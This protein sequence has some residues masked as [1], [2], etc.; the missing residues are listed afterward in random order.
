[1]IRADA[2]REFT[3]R[4]EYTVGRHTFH[5]SP[6][7]VKQIDTCGRIGHLSGQPNE[8]NCVPGGGVPSFNIRAFPLFPADDAGRSGNP[9][10]H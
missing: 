7:S 1:V 9:P 6:D 10:V 8:G 5:L 3:N 4:I 2:V